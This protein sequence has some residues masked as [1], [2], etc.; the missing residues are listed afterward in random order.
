[1]SLTRHPISVCQGSDGPK[2]S[3]ETQSVTH[4]SILV[5][6]AM[7]LTWCWRVMLAPPAVWDWYSIQMVIGQW[8]EVT[9]DLVF[10]LKWPKQNKQTNKNPFLC[11][12][13]LLKGQQIPF[14]KVLWLRLMESPGL[15]SQIFFSISTHILYELSQLQCFKYLLYADFQ[16]TVLNPDILTLDS[17]F[18]LLP[19]HCVLD[20]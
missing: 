4:P 5:C 18:Q 2:L 17:E 10:W 12:F 16:F 8:V 11:W 9:L 13:Y 20:I 6:T 15:S 7:S 1:M 14:W 19:Q 3:L